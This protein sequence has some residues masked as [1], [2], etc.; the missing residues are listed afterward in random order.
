[1]AERADLFI[2]PKPGTDLV[3]ISALTRYVLDNGLAKTAF[4]DKWVNGLEEYKK[5]LEPFT[6]EF[7]AQ[8]CG[9]P[10]ET[11][12][13]VAHLIAEAERAC[14]LWAMGVT[15]HTIGSAASTTISTPLLS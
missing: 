3:W 7:A 14:I 15:Q 4:L 2:H 11:L 6:M 13:K 1:M 9:L 8:T 5:S 12:K 10:I